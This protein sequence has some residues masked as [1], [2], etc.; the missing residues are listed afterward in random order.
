MNHKL[1]RPKLIILPETY[2]EKACRETLAYMLTLEY[3][4]AMLLNISLPKPKYVDVFNV[5]NNNSIYLLGVKQGDQLISGEIIYHIL[6][7]PPTRELGSIC[8]RIKKK[9]LKK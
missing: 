2:S 9:S 5:M 7:P 3:I 4:I 8:A 6:W 1:K